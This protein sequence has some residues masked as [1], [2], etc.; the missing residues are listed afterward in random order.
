MQGATLFALPWVASKVS[1]N[2]T[3][4]RVKLTFLYKNRHHVCIPSHAAV[5]TRR[6]ITRATAT[7]TLDD[8]RTVGYYRIMPATELFLCVNHTSWLQ[9]HADVC[10]VSS[11]SLRK[12]YL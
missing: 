4:G 3:I 7:T 9:H 8:S 5:L 10:G 12:A 6:S 2:D 11:A 1:S